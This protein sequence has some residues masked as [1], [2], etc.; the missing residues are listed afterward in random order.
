MVARF[1]WNAVHVQGWCN[2]SSIENISRW[3]ITDYLLYLGYV[4]GGDHLHDIPDSVVCDATHHALLHK[5]V[6]ER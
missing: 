6:Q 4:V 5:Q 3:C 1:Q 2:S